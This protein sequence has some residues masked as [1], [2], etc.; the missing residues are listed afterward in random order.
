MLLD[1]EVVYLIVYC[2]SRLTNIFNISAIF[3]V[4]ARLFSLLF[5]VRDSS[6]SSSKRISLVEKLYKLFK[7]SVV[8]LIINYPHLLF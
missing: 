5:K 8:S 7:V 1:Y 4:S 6:S 3:L 2:I